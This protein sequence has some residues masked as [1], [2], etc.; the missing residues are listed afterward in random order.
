MDGLAPAPRLSQ[1][2]AGYNTE[3]AAKQESNQEQPIANLEE[4]LRRVESEL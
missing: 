2:R 3:T 4:R 1:G